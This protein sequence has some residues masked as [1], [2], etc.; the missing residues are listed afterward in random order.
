MNIKKKKKGDYW[1]HM[2][3]SLM[4]IIN[5]KFSALEK[6]NNIEK[7]KLNRNL[8]V[9]E[10]WSSIFSSSFFLPPIICKHFFLPSKLFENL[11]LIPFSLLR[12]YPALTGVKCINWILLGLNFNTQSPIPSSKKEKK[13][14]QTLGWIVQ[15]SPH[16]ERPPDNTNKCFTFASYVSHSYRKFTQPFPGTSTK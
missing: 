16:D 3:K 14:A 6:S 11:N 1:Y 10:P 4:H 13:K 8:K 2:N 15:T 9:L 12:N 5:A 7:Y